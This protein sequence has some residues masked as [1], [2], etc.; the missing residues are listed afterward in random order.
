MASEVSAAMD[1][2]PALTAF[3][4]AMQAA[5]DRDPA[6]IEVIRDF[7][8]SSMDDID[9]LFGFFLK[10]IDPAQCPQPGA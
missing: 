5:L 2:S 1:A 4:V 8:I 9:R 3:V 6:I 7:R 10:T